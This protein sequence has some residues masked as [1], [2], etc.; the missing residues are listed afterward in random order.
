[1][2]LVALPPCISRIA[3]LRCCCCCVFSMCLA[4]DDAPLCGSL[5]PL[6]RCGC[7]W[8]TTRPRELGRDTFTSTCTPATASTDMLPF[9]ICSSATRRTA[10]RPRWIACC[11][12]CRLPPWRGHA[13]A[14]PRS[15]STRMSSP[16]FMSSDTL[17]MAYAPREMVTPRTSPNVSTETPAPPRMHQPNAASSI[18]PCASLA[19]KVRSPSHRSTRTS[20]P[21]RLSCQVPATLW[22]RPPRCWKIGAGSRLSWRACR[23]ITSRAL[24]YPAV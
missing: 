9:S 6:T 15:C 20:C 18:L 2:L 17:C 7:S 5:L 11:A 10:V 12:T 3:C 24:A 19:S 22:R 13:K 14:N 23:S 21:E 16:S 1:M 4:I 8:S